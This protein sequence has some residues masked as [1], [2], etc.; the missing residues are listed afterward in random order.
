MKKILMKLNNLSVVNNSNNEILNT[1]VEMEKLMLNENDME[2]KNLNDI[3][4]QSISDNNLEKVNY[5][6]NVLKLTISKNFLKE[7]QNLF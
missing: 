5:L 4:W 1:I 3:F 6:K 7:N 2:A